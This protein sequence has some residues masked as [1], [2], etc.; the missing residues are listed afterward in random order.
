MNK[1]LFY[2]Y[3]YY[4]DDDDYYYQESLL[5]MSLMVYLLQQGSNS[6]HNEKYPWRND[7]IVPRPALSPGFRWSYNI[8]FVQPT[9]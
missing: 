4:Y 8:H 6:Y 9:K 5:L 3:H 1:V 2:Y 7:D